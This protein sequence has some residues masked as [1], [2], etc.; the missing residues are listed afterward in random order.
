MAQVKKSPL[1]GPAGFALVVAIHVVIIWGFQNGLASFMVNLVNGPMEASLVEETK[2][3]AEAPPPPPPKFQALPPPVI[4]PV[5]IA[6]AAPEAVA[7]TA[8][9]TTAK[10]QAAPPA[11][12]ARDI[13]IPPKSNP[14]RPVTQPE[15]PPTSK[16]LGEAG[17]V[18]MLLTV[19]EEGRVTEAKI[20]KSSGYERLDE[21]AL[22]EALNRWRLVAGTVNGKASAMQYK[23][24]VT[25]KLTD[26]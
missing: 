26:N 14:R 23:F 12:V 4:I 22:K 2:V 8:I 1:R 17:T 20:D 10:K 18:V 19:S 3:D 24:A 16:R 21:A 13:I 15:Y 9:D 25:F 7:S 11:P 5:D 6:V